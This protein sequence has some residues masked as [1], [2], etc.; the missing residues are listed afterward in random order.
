MIIIIP[1]VVNNDEWSTGIAITNLA[2]VKAFVTAVI[3]DEKGK[4][5]SETE[6]QLNPFAIE[7]FMFHMPGR[8]SLMIGGKD[9]G[10]TALL[11][12]KSSG[13]QSVL[14]VVVS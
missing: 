3:R 14:P 6:I 11:I 10:V 13:C 1:Y 5:L 12:N 7:A 4:Q 2:N 9:I 8:C